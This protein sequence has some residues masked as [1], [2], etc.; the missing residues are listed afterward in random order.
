MFLISRGKG[1]DS[2]TKNLFSTFDTDKSGT[3]D[4][5]WY[6]EDL[7]TENLIVHFSFI[8]KDDQPVEIEDPET[9]INPEEPIR[10][11][12]KTR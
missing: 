12:E 1:R 10:I 11:E 4:F 8:F 6:Q 5:R 7:C 2:F 9:I 3:I